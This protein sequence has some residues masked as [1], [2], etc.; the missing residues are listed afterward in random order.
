M[1]TSRGR[2][3]HILL[4]Q[5]KNIDCPRRGSYLFAMKKMKLRTKII[6]WV[7]AVLLILYNAG[8]NVL[9]SAALKPDFMRKL[10]AF[11][12]VTDKSYSEMVQT[13]EITENT[14]KAREEA[15]AFVEKADGSKVRILSYDGYQLI[16]SVFRQPEP[17]G[18]PW[19]ILLHGYTGWKEEMYHYAARYYDEGFNILCPDLRCQGQSEGDFIGMGWTDR[20]DVVLW[21]NEILASYPDAKIVIHGESMGASCALMMMGLILPENVVCIISD[22]A[23]EDAMS[24]F[25]KQLRDWFGIPDIG[26]IGSARIWLLIRGGY[27]LKDASALNEVTKG[28]VPVLFIHG[29]EDRLVPAGDAKDLYEDCASP[30]KEIMIVQGAGHAQ[31]CYRDPDAYYAEVFGFIEECM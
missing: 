24:M 5:H 30:E 7:L 28:S 17:E 19:V 22:C 26:L 25:R 6:I 23:M 13:D 20:E 4:I 2:S 8:V 15:K 21:M 18:R 29:D 10:D 27:D 1:R 3:G 14:G 11:Q 12:R 31:S 9:I 16:A